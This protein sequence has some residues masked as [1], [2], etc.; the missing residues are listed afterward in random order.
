MTLLENI[1]G[2]CSGYFLG[3]NSE[4]C[5]TSLMFE[6]MEMFILLLDITVGMLAIK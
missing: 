2:N 1:D 5:P 4:N 6:I 3:V